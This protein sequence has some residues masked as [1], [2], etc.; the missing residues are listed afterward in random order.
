MEVARRPWWRM[1]AL[2]QQICSFTSTSGWASST[3]M[4]VASP[5][6]AANIIGE[7]TLRS[8]DRG[9][10]PDR[11]T[12]RTARSKPAFHAPEHETEAA[13]SPAD[14][15]SAILRQSSRLWRAARSSDSTIFQNI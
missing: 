15:I 9:I 4:A 2:R 11:M 6:R 12:P 5:Q 7:N 3:S 13:D 8:L 14:F 1:Q 10:V